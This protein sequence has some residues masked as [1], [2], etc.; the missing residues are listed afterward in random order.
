MTHTT[1]TRTR[2]STAH[3]ISELRSEIESLKSLVLAQNEVVSG[4]AALSEAQNERLAEHEEYLQITADAIRT[5]QKQAFKPASAPKEQK[6][7]QKTERKTTP[8]KSSGLS[9]SQLSREG[10]KSWNAYAFRSKRYG[11]SKEAWVRWSIDRL[12][13]TF[14]RD[15]V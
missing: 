5:L 8:K 11:K 12:T 15:I 3:S 1:T 10:R 4:L 9:W 14:P 6:T 7:E 13:M 2:K